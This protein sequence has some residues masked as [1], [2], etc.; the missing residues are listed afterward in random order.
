MPENDSSRRPY[1]DEGEVATTFHAIRDQ[2]DRIE[3]Q[4]RLT[5]GRVR[6]LESWR[7]FMAG[8]IA[9]LTVLSGWVMFLISTG[10]LK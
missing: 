4:V 10:H 9:I 1:A 8:A 3:V 5:N 7:A 2:L 6:A